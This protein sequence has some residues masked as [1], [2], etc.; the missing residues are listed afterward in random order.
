MA[1]RVRLPSAFAVFVFLHAAIL[2][3]HER[4]RER[5]HLQ[6][7]LILHRR[8]SK[9]VRVKEDREELLWETKTFHAVLTEEQNSAGATLVKAQRQSQQLHLGFKT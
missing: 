2:K 5:A 6:L 1:E 3:Q 8:K 4:Q 7:N 9:L